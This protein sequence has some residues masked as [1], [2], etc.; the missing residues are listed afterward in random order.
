MRPCY[1]TSQICSR[2]NG[3]MLGKL[4]LAWFFWLAAVDS[5]RPQDVFTYHNDNGRTGL[6][7]NETILTP[8][9]VN[10]SSFGKLYVLSLDGRVDAQPLYMS[11][12]AI[13]GR[14]THNVL[15]V[16]TEHDTVY[17][18]DADNGTALWQVSLLKSGEAPSDDRSCSQVTPE[19]GITATP[20][21]DPASGSNGT[22]YLVAMSKDA[23]GNYHQ[24]LHAL[25]VTT[26][27]EE[28]GGPIN[29][30]AT[31]PGTGDNHQN[32]LVVF[33]PK[34]YKE[35]PGL[36]L[37][38]NV[39]YTTWSSHCDHR[40]YTG[41][42]IGYDESTLSQISVLNI[43]PNGN[44]GA[45]WASGAGPA[46]D[47]SGNIYFLAGNGTFDT[48]L[49]SNGFPS[50]GDYGNAFLKLSTTNS[51]LAVAD[52][53]AMYNTV[54]ESNAD[55]DL[56]SGGTL[57]LP[58]LID[59]HG[60]TRYLAIGA[61]KD[62]N[63]Y[64][65]DR[66]NMGKFNSSTN[67]AIYQELVGALPNG[68]WS[69]PA[70]FNGYIYYG[71]VGQPIQQFQFSNA[72][73]LSTP[74]SKTTNIFNYPGATP[75]VSANGT[76][77]GIV[78]ASKNGNPAVLYAYDATNLANELYNSNQAANGRDHFGTGNKFVT[79]TIANGKVYVGTTT[80]VATFGLLSPGGPA[81]TLSP[82]K[83]SFASQL[84][85]TTSKTQTI[86]MTNSGSASI[87]ISRIT[88]SGDF[89]Q[90]NTCGTNL[91]A[92]AN[93]TIIVSFTPSIVGTVPG[94]IT[95]V[96]DAVNSPQVAGLTG[97]SVDDVTLSPTSINFGTI[98]VGSTSTAQTV[99]VT[100]NEPTSVNFG[101]ST[102]ADYAV[103]G[104]GTTCGSMLVAKSK[105][106]ISIVFQPSQNSVT[107]GALGVTSPSFSTQVVSLTG[108]G[109]G[110]AASA[111]SFS[112]RSSGF[113]NQLIGRTSSVKTV[114][115][116]NNSGSAVTISSLRASSDYTATG[117][118]VTPCGG[119]LAAQKTCTFAV[120]FTPS[121]RG[122]IKGAVAISDNS[123][124]TP[125]L[126][127]LSGTGVLAVTFSPNSLAF[128][129]QTI[130]ST[131]APQTV[132]LFNNQSTA[133]TI[134]SIVASGQY[135]ANSGGSNPCGTSLG[136]HASCTFVVTFTPSSTGTIPGVVTVLHDASGSP[137]AVKLTGMG[138]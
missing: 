79:P 110:G 103:A 58:N 77:N 14:G 45:I 123:A 132:V 136:S 138:Q 54:A 44:E 5:A 129:T 89:A 30:R 61:G 7:S 32:G 75:S 3:S 88:S 93:C 47:T 36:L 128:S 115:V 59:S 17:A 40:P 20:V 29:I 122:I 86:K 109:S 134:N 120:S 62:T 95:I 124:V 80:G 4:F 53:F 31:F 108:T 13:T 37:V 18:F 70:Y 130:G 133:L 68:I 21:I 107:N 71:A 98:V 127:N 10:V 66:N 137:Q 114:Q 46:A 23:S 57:V 42:V 43:T 116:T 50:K 19:I 125:Q 28:F 64:L 135:T 112:P 100:N 104:S 85:S 60:T 121:I 119:S 55:T 126:Y 113:G 49:N 81:V 92:G 91:G 65:V 74:V 131:S 106:T 90:T 78:W 87:S 73:L 9:N 34:Q 22:I 15:F 96:D 105:C 83:L 82:I 63:M 94:A 24:R 35:R 97:T 102:S 39:V 111:L 27:Q 51:A 56:G 48:E 117:S 67:S 33:D 2:S 84:I 6:N 38:N 25:D 118:G 101:F 26:G 52:Y 76:S 11:T 16:A 8:S 12:V 69:M 72:K 99:T 41:W 1:G